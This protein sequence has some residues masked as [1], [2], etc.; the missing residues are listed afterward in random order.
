MFFRKSDACDQPNSQTPM[1]AAAIGRQNTFV[2]NT[3]AS[4]TNGNDALYSLVTRLGGNSPASAVGAAGVPTTGTVPATS[5]PPITAAA[6][7]AGAGASVAGPSSAGVV[8]ARAGAVPCVVPDVVPFSRVIALPVI[9]TPVA[10]PS[11]AAKAPAP[12]APAPA[13]TVAAAPAGRCTDPPECAPNADNICRLITEGCVSSN[14]VS[15]AQALLCAWSGWTSS[16]TKRGMCSIYGW[17][18]GEYLGTMNPRP[19]NQLGLWY[20][21]PPAYQAAI[22]AGMNVRNGQGP[23]GV[24]GLD[25][26]TT[27]LNIVLA[28]AAAAGVAWWYGKKG[29]R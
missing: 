25:L 10:Q 18:N 28:V 24:S 27:G 1:S 22:D 14:Q 4:F 15:K 3:G 16:M 21:P 19:V 5:L 26:P 17:N 23:P 29:R 11:P 7:S 8:D 9:A 2:A 6:A 12:A 13:A 20:D